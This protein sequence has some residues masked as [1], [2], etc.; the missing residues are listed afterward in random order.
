MRKELNSDVKL[1][2]TEVK[3][4]NVNL[5]ITFLYFHKYIHFISSQSRSLG[6]KNHSA[7]LQQKYN[8]ITKQIFENK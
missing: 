4:T 8:L 2:C 5:V 6:E 1:F 3:Y 7:L